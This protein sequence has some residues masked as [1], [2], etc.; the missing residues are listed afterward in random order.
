ML[1]LGR[2]V[3][4]CSGSVMLGCHW[5]HLLGSLALTIISWLQYIVL[6]VPFFN[7][8]YWY[9]ISLLL[10]TLNAILLINV[11]A[12]DPGILPR[13]QF[14][15]ERSASVSIIRKDATVLKSNFCKICNI[16]RPARARH[17]KY[18]D[19]CVDIFDHHCPVS[20]ISVSTIILYEILI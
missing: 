8:H 7:W 5:R 13:Q 18:C 6:L 16:W 3:F 19:N 9:I 20:V 10:A 15:N 4:L 12:T 17:C 11:S 14:K 2:N 1:F